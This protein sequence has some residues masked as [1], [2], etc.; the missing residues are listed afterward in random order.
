MDTL[1]NISCT[2][3]PH[4]PITLSLPFVYLVI[5]HMFASSIGAVGTMAGLNHTARQQF[6][7]YCPELKMLFPVRHYPNPSYT[8]D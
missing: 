7:D 2:L 3:D 1:I 6:L 5:F 8:Q 4:T